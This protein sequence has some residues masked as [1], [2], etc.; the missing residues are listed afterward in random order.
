MSRP[1]SRGRAV[2][3]GSRHVL[4]VLV[5]VIS[6]GPLVVLAATALKTNAELA[7]NPLGPPRQWVFSNFVE[8]YV[9]ARMGSFLLNSIA[10]VVP[11]LLIV[12]VVA[13]AAGYAIARFEFPGKRILLLVSLVGLVIPIISIV[14]PVYY[15]MQDL[16]LSDS[17]V[18]LILADSAQAL[19]IAIFVMRATFL[20]LPGEL[21][22]AALVDG[23]SEVRAFRSVMLPMARGG[24]A[25]T[26]V[27]TF[28]ATWND[29]LLPL[30]L[31]NTESLRTL[32]LGLSYLQGR[33]ITDLPLLAA[34]TL[35]TAVPSI[36][37]YIL[38]QRQF[39]NGV[40][41]GAIK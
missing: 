21:R 17:L 12:L 29:F 30:V 34:A 8:A 19:P 35:L 1:I 28:L 26:A 13:S 37:V 5:A 9:S 2:A 16:R 27:L 31:I 15:L 24:L 40:I 11:T 36:V 33:Y 7:V 20:D 38:L 3:L 18:G 22:E 25:A 14:V 41:Q 23:A 32:P 39:T 6:L 10:V 4:L